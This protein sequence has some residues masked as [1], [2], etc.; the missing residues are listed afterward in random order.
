MYQLNKAAKLL[1][2]IGE[3]A[4]KSNKD[5]FVLTKYTLM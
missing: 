3:N 1:K 4:I 5:R 2:R